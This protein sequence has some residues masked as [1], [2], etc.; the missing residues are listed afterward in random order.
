VEREGACYHRVV[1]EPRSGKRAE[2]ADLAAV[3]RS[4]SAELIQGVLYTLPR[5]RPRHQRAGTATS[6]ALFGPFDDGQGGPGGWWILSE[7]G[8][9][10]A[11]LD[12]VEI[13]PDV[14]GWRRERMPELPDGPITLA[15]DWA[16]EILSPTTRAHDQRIKRPLYAKAG[17]RWLW[18]VDVDAR[19]LTASRLENGR[20]SELGV[21]AD[22]E[23]ARIEPFEAI[24][25]RLGDLWAPSA[26]PAR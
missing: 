26:S 2:R 14:A 9:E 16:C 10:L 20:W 24:E 22:A 4:M 25:F 13:S 12:V 11:D 15:P 18:F 6:S 19:T 17:V 3:P 5:P 21:W 7:P 1:S 23:I 8:I